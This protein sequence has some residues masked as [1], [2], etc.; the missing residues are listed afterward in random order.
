MR[1]AIWGWLEATGIEAAVEVGGEG[2]A[3][4][5]SG[6]AREVEDLLVGVQGFGRPV[7]R[8]LGEEAML[9]RI[10]FGSTG[11]IVGHGHGEGK[12]VGQLGL[13]FGFPGVAAG[14]LWPTSC[15]RTRAAVIG[16][17]CPVP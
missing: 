4:L 16:L 6:G 12:G 13:E 5:G 14:A 9:D 8:N 15:S 3:G 1:F 17:P 11:G 7:S 2:E 10:P